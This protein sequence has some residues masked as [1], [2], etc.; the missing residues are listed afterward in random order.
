MYFKNF[1]EKKP[2]KRLSNNVSNIRRSSKLFD[3]LESFFRSVLERG[4]SVVW[5]WMVYGQRMLD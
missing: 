4:D 1:G 2:E 5:D 3:S